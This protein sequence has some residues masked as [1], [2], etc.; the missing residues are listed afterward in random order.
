MREP[1]RK[2]PESAAPLDP[3]AGAGARVEPAE[4]RVG[5]WGPGPGWGWRSG[6]PRRESP[7]SRRGAPQACSLPG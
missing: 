1:L 6:A 2:D 4:R 5:V 3:G 7:A